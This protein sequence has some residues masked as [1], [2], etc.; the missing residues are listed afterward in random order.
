MSYIDRNNK[1]YNNLNV[2][3]DNIDIDPEMEE[4]ENFIVNGKKLNPEAQLFR[5]YDRILLNFTY[6]SGQEFDFVKYNSFRNI[7]DSLSSS[8]KSGSYDYE[9]VKKVMVHLDL[10]L[11]VEVYFVSSLSKI[12]ENGL[13]NIKDYSQFEVFDYETLT[14]HY[15]KRY[16]KRLK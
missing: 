12:I 7:I 16:N 8:L 11:G 3:V 1:F 5:E 10:E 4:Y 14:A 13:E 15:Y 9:T 6:L 2:A